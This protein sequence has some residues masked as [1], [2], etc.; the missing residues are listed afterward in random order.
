MKLLISSVI[1]LLYFYL[2]SKEIITKGGSKR[3]DDWLERF[4]EFKKIVEYKKKKKFQEKDFCNFKSWACWLPRRTPR[5]DTKNKN[6]KTVTGFLKIQNG[7]VQDAGTDSTFEN[8]IKQWYDRQTE[9]KELQKIAKNEFKQPFI[10]FL[11]EHGIYNEST[12]KINAKQR[13]YKNQNT[14]RQQKEKVV[15]NN[16]KRPQSRKQNNDIFLRPGP[17]QNKGN[18][19][20]YEN[21]RKNGDNT[22]EKLIAYIHQN[23][24]FP[25]SNSNLMKWY[26]DEK[27]ENFMEKPRWITKINYLKWMEKAIKIINKKKF[28]TEDISWYND[29]VELYNDLKEEQKSLIADIGKLM[30]PVFNNMTNNIPAWMKNM[31]E[32][33]EYNKILKEQSNIYARL[34]RLRQKYQNNSDS[35]SENDDD[36]EEEARAPRGGKRVRGFGGKFAAKFPQAESEEED[37]GSESDDE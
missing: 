24:K 31:T 33:S 35:E 27:D 17:S 1:V 5:K 14:N 21:Y 36:E 2:C 13:I 11:A 28:S 29:Q 7:N 25:R 30:N 4:E 6:E 23:K 8:S 37:S 26:E 3:D 20:E 10:V 15:R 12:G 18:Y 22:A 16:K 9:S 32:S 34:N 19:Y